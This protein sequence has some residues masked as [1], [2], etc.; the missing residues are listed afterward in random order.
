MEWSVPAGL[1]VLT[2]CTL[3]SWNGP[4]LTIWFKEAVKKSMSKFSEFLISLNPSEIKISFW[5]IY[6]SSLSVIAPVLSLTSTVPPRQAEERITQLSD[7][8]RGGV[9]LALSAYSASWRSQGLSWKQRTWPT[10]HM[11]CGTNI[12]PYLSDQFKLL[13]HLVNVSEFMPTL[14]IGEE[15]I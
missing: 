14:N 13:V 6:F 8:Q 12:H 11:Q 15:R 7:T 4:K 5:K 10:V 1:V 9:W 2:M 3:A